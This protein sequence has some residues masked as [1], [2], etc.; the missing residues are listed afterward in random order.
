LSGDIALKALDPE[1]A[2]AAYARACT[3]ADAFAQADASW[4]APLAQAWERL[5]QVGMLTQRFASARDA[6]ARAR[7]LLEMSDPRIDARL[8]LKE[9]QAALDAGDMS[10]ARAAF[11]QSCSTRL[12][13]LDASPGDITL[14]RELAVSLERLGM[15]AKTAGDAKAARAAWED[16][17]RLADMV[18]AAVPGEDATRFCAI[19]HA[20]LATLNGQ[21]ARAHTVAASELLSELEAIGRLTER[22][23]ALRAQLGSSKAAGRAHK[24]LRRK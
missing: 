7:K 4:R 11:S 15:L 13:L 22:D 1:A 9:G 21:D 19:V 6:F 23:V 8:A 20:H 16:E 2:R 12:D 17:L 3:T 5:G 10:G 24:K 18:R 14:T